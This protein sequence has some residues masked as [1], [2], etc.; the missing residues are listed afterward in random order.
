MIC[1]HAVGGPWTESLIWYAQWR[2][3]RM[4][5]ICKAREREREQCFYTVIANSG[6]IF[7]WNSVLCRYLCV[8][9][10]VCERMCDLQAVHHSTSLSSVIFLLPFVH[11]VNEFEEGAFRHRSV[12]IHGPAQE[13]ELLHHTIPILRLESKHSQ[14][15]S[16]ATITTKKKK[17]KIIQSQKKCLAFN[18]ATW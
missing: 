17:G 3:C 14:I 5:L 2:L 7:N 15:K 1:F 8:C 6:L 13:L 10:H 4:R 16:T 12:P 9:A 18:L 11:L